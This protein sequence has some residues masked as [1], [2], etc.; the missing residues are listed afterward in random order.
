MRIAC[1]FVAVSMYITFFL[2]SRKGEVIETELNTKPKNFSA[3]APIEI[4]PYLSQ[5][6]VA[7]INELLPIVY[8]VP[9]PAC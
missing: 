4:F 2:F 7:V 9:S 5:K 3:L 8:E 6:V 1:E